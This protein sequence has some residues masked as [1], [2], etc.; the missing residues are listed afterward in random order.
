M[1]S[2]LLRLVRLSMK[3]CEEAR[4]LSER[5]ERWAYLL[6]TVS[7][8]WLR[9]RLINGRLFVQ[10]A[11]IT[12]GFWKKKMIGDLQLMCEHE[13]T[14]RSG[15]QY[16]SFLH[17]RACSM[18]L[19]YLTV[20]ERSRAQARRGLD[21]PRRK[22]GTTSW[23]E[24]DQQRPKKPA[25]QRFNTEGRYPTRTSPTS[26]KQGSASAPRPNLEQA[27][28]EMMRC[29]QEGMQVLSTQLQHVAMQQADSAMALTQTM[30]SLQQS[31]EA[32]AER[33]RKK[34]AGHQDPAQ[35]FHICSGS[36]IER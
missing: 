13:D 12:P 4:Q 23:S 6:L 8:S 24:W 28:I 1:P 3:V 16:G 36:D 35:E 29:Q 17:C 18:R 34:S 31:M 9:R 2:N 26:T 21:K 30:S 32:I 20:D 19:Q 27:L 11:R 7:L 10:Q 33:P 15:N 14:S 22:P 5:A 25:E